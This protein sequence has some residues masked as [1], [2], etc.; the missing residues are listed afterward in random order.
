MDCALGTIYNIIISYLKVKDMYDSN[1]FSLFLF[2]SE[3][4]DIRVPYRHQDL[5]SIRTIEM[6][7]SRFRDPIDINK[8]NVLDSSH[9]TFSKIV[10]HSREYY[11]LRN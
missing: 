7:V 4:R 1:D 5:F 11:S 2:L 3:E 9:S 10:G 8:K 6:S